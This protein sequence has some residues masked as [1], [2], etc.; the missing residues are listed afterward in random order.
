[1][2]IKRVVAGLTAGLLLSVGVAWAENEASYSASMAPLNTLEYLPSCVGNQTQEIIRKPDQPSRLVMHTVLEQVLLNGDPASP[3]ILRKGPDDRDA[4]TTYSWNDQENGFSIYGADFCEN[5]VCDSMRF[6]NPLRIPPQVMP[7]M[8]YSGTSDITYNGINRGN[9]QW[10]VMAEIGGIVTT[11]A[12]TFTDTLHTTWRL[13]ISGKAD[14]I[15][16]DWLARGIGSVKG[17]TPGGEQTELAW[18]KICGTTV[19]TLLV[20]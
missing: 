18:A 14:G 11:P 1:M 3:E 17:V 4:V 7:G 10:S 5:S 12:G 9:I 20:Q 19:G 13:Q 16:E 15:A 8:N 2:R 6:T